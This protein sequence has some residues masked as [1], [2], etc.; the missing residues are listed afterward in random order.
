[1]MT[2]S[3]RPIRIISAGGGG[4]VLNHEVGPLYPAGRCLPCLLIWYRLTW[5]QPGIKLAE[6]YRRRRE[7]DSAAG[8]SGQ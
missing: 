3:V 1:M 8:K 6:L 4:Q 5:E 2:G 7:E